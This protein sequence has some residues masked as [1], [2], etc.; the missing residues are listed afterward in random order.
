MSTT[1]ELPNTSRILLERCCAP[2]S[3]RV[4]TVAAESLHFPAGLYAEN[5]PLPDF[6]AADFAAPIVV[7]REKTGRLVVIDGHK[8]LRLLRQR[9]YSTI[10]C[11]LSDI[12]VAEKDLGPLRVAFNSRRLFHIR[13]KLALAV[14]SLRFPELSTAALAPV[15]TPKQRGMLLALASAN[16]QV[17]D[18]IAAGALH[19]EV[20]AD[21][22]RLDTYDQ[23]CFLDAFSR[24]RLSVQ[25]QRQLL[26]WLPEIAARDKKTIRG[27]LGGDAVSGV[28][29]DKRINDPQRIQKIRDIV[30]LWRFPALAQ[31]ERSWKSQ[32]TALNPA[33]SRVSIAHAPFFERNGA[34][35]TILCLD[36]NE[37]VSILAQLASRPPNAWKELIAPLS[38]NA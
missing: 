17:I 36:E 5:A 23:R 16:E 31:T 28:L 8:R 37:T 15:V 33:P 14:W 12:S 24:L 26:E 3:L 21:F 11:M 6:T 29:N 7:L 4:A 30:Y 19:I 2:E 35:I 25:M 22:L 1:G 20:V 9:G 32:A 13:E 18:A 34:R 38:G 10:T 27:L